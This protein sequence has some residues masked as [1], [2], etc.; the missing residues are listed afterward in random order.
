M[1]LDTADL[2]SPYGSAGGPVGT[3]AVI[4]NGPNCAWVAKSNAQW[5]SVAPASGTGNQTLQVTV[6]SNSGSSTPRSTDLT[7]AGQLISITQSG[8]ACTYALQSS[9]GAVPAQGG[10][11]AVGVV[12]P[13][14]CGW[15]AVS[16]DPTWLTVL[17]PGSTG[18]SN[19]AFSV[20]PNPTSSLRT[21][22]LT[23]ESLTYT[24]TQ[25]AASCSYTLAPSGMS[26][27]FGGGGGTFGFSTA[28]EGCSPPTGVSFADWVRIT[29]TSSGGTVGS[30]TFE[31]QA[32]PTAVARQASRR[33]A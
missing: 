2:G 22:T 5:A 27:P 18:T 10:Q 23:I 32:N 1:T 33:S 8:I 13:A 21:G 28:T 15:S 20:L 17:S 16:N 3:I 4:A 11:G 31:V 24:V 30:V 7:V 12:A 25:A 26:V 14:A 9:T 19:V 6:T 29:N